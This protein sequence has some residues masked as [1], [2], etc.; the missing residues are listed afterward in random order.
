MYASVGPQPG[1]PG[2]M[3]QAPT[4]V[5]APAGAMAGVPVSQPVTSPM[6]QQQQQQLPPTTGFE[7]RSYKMRCRKLNL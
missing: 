4:T 5:T 3:Q 7:S 1:L 6:P 2:G